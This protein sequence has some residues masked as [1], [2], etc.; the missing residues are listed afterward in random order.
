MAGG[1]LASPG[2][3]Y[4]E[5]GAAFVRVAVVQPMERLRL[6]GERLAGKVLSPG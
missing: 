4:G 5:D 6:V 2:D 3:L 1:L